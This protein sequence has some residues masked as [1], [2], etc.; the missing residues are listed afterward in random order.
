MIIEDVYK[1]T[2]KFD[3]YGKKV[4]GVL[5]YDGDDIHELT[6]SIF[7]Q[8][9]W[10]I[11]FLNIFFKENGLT[12]YYYY[13]MILNRYYFRLDGS[14]TNMLRFRNELRYMFNLNELDD[15]C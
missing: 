2:M 13:D 6:S 9:S 12:S 8:T 11:K 4:I 5:C 10:F 1:N 15:W 7:P 14:I 3:I